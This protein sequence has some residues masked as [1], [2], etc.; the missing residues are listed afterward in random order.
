MELALKV[1]SK[2]RQGQRFAVYIVLP[3]WPEGAPDSASVQEIL[4]FQVP[5]TCL[6]RTKNLNHTLYYCLW[7]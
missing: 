6:G 4:Y 3:M 2:I 5:Y 1:A 7:D